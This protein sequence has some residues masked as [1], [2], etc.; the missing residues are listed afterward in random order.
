MKVVILVC[1]RCGG[2]T[3]VYPGECIPSFCFYCGGYL[4]YKEERE[5]G[6]IDDD[7]DGIDSTGCA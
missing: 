6:G 4:R 1:T 2:E 7:D 5:D 3:K